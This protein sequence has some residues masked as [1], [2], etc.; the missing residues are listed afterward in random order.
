M[1]TVSQPA[2]RTASAVESAPRR[3]AVRCTSC[4]AEQ[5]PAPLCASCGGVVPLPPDADPYLVFGI[6]RRPDLDTEALARRY[7][8]LSRLLHPD[9]HSAGSPETRQAS[10]QNTAAL[11]R[12][13]RTLR[14]P[15]GRGRNWIELHG[16]PLGDDNRVPPELAAL[17]FEVQEKL[18]EVRAASRGERGALAAGI[19]AELATLRERLAGDTAAVEECF[20]R[21]QSPATVGEIKSA[22][23]RRAYLATL[24]R[25]VERALEATA[26]EEK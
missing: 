2:P 25:D 10:M 22:L 26:G 18:D 1:S 20:A 12:A 24:V 9:R 8:E 6:A 19:R 23:S 3:D 5:A 14:D 15:V 11:T 4:G 7:Y 13:Y 17:V 16:E 21:W